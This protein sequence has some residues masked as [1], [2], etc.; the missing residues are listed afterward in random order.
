MA[1]PLTN[2]ITLYRGDDFSLPV[3]IQVGG[4]PLNLTGATIAS[5]I[6]ATA[7]TTGSPL[8]SFTIGS[9]VAASGQFT[10]SLTGTQTAALDPLPSTAVYDLQIVASGITTTYFGGTVTMGLDVTR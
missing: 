1:L 2:N 4:S 10:M 9:I 6:R 5:M 3:T 7:N 8:A